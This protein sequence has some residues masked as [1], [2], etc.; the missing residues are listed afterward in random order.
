[1]SESSQVSAKARACFHPTPALLTLSAVTCRF[2][3]PICISSTAMSAGVNPIHSAGANGLSDICWFEPL[4]HAID[5][6]VSYTY[7]SPPNCNGSCS[8]HTLLTPDTPLL[9]PPALSAAAAPRLDLNGCI[10]SA[11]LSAG[12]AASS[13]LAWTICTVGLSLCSKPWLYTV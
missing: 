6:V 4:Q 1:M 11:E 12:F 3:I 8:L 9:A 13:L 7:P 5:S 10:S 2:C